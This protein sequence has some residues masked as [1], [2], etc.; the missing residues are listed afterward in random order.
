MNSIKTTIA[1]VLTTFAFSNLTEM[2]TLAQDRLVT[3][4]D[5]HQVYKHIEQNQPEKADALLDK[6]EEIA[7][8]STVQ[9]MTLQ[10]MRISLAGEFALTKF[11]HDAALKQMRSASLAYR[12]HIDESAT[13]ECLALVSDSMG[14]LF[15]DNKMKDIT[16]HQQEAFK[17]VGEN[18]TALRK[19]EKNVSRV[20]KHIAKCL[21]GRA[22]IAIWLTDNGIENQTVKKEIS[23]E[24]NRLQEFHKAEPNN[25]DGIL[26]LIE[27]LNAGLEPKGLFKRAEVLVKKEKLLTDAL[28]N[29]D[30]SIEVA[31]AYR[32]VLSEKAG[33]IGV[34]DTKGEA[35]M[36]AIIAA[37]KKLGLQFPGKFDKLEATLKKRKENY[38][39]YGKNGFN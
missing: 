18:I 2:P 13:W 15:E 23:D 14:H 29:P 25:K 38:L 34:H 8:D 17:L 20:T 6:L 21:G 4:K 19:K 26:A 10:S 11:D 35:K 37:G 28:N 1:L 33:S 7:G 30:V 24:L 22:K 39:K 31:R 9:S 27:I 12:K 3:P 16:K 36:D 32:L 5:I